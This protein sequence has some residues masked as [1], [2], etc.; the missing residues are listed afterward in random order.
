VEVLPLVGRD[1]KT[2]ALV[3]FNA[4][5]P[6]WS[7]LD[8]PKEFKHWLR[9]RSENYGYKIEVAR[10]E[11]F[12]IFWADGPSD[13]VCNGPRFWHVNDETPAWVRRLERPRQLELRLQRCK[14]DLGYLEGQW[15]EIAKAE[16]DK[17]LMLQAK[18]DELKA[19]PLI[20]LVKLS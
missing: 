19:L 13:A 2:G 17:R 7:P 6:D 4:R 5:P 3:R 8:G 1:T 18:Y 12:A 15:R 16:L 10:H 20:V 14:I 11:G 9:H